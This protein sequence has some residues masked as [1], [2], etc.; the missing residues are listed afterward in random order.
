MSKQNNE[1]VTA[2]TPDSLDEYFRAGVTT[3]HL[4][5]RAPRC[6]LLIDPARQT[7]ELLTPAI[8]VEPDLPGLERVSIETVAMEDGQWF[9]LLIDAR[10]LRHEAYGLVVAIAQAMRT[11]VTFAAATLA[12]LSNMRAVLATRHRLSPDQQVGLLGELL[13]LRSLLRIHSE[14]TVIGWWL[15]P[16][17][18]QHDLACEDYDVEIK[19][20]TSERRIHVIHGTGQLQRNPARPLWLL[21]I[22]LTRAGGGSGVSLAAAVTG[23]LQQLTN[24]RDAFRDHLARLGWRDQDADL[25]RDAYILRDAPLAFPVDDDFPAITEERL[26]RVVPHADL[27][28]GISYRVDLTGR[29]PGDP[30]QPIAYVLATTEFLDV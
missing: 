19:T 24:R 5:A 26:A 6:E 27:V 16:L 18:E 7:Y 20:A 30:G 22:R 15:G 25:Y 17:A 3:S 21:S 11:G 1:T 12:A 10:D 2:L 8:G 14:E 29:T 4:L 28:S 23:I 13:V 9:R